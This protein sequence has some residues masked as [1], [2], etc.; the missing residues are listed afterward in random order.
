MPNCLLYGPI[1]HTHVMLR[2][3]RL[4]EKKGGPR[5]KTKSDV[6]NIQLSLELAEIF[7]KHAPIFF[8]KYVQYLQNS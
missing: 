6:E 3:S 8:L 5:G 7:V 1:Q 2:K 4:K